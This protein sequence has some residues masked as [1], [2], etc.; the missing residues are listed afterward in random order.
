MEPLVP[1][2]RRKEFAESNSKPITVN[3]SRF[4]LRKFFIN[5]NERPSIKG[6]SEPGR[7]VN[8]EHQ[9]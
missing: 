6:Y 5:T 3:D 7:G 4:G 1:V 2:K 8:G 9:N